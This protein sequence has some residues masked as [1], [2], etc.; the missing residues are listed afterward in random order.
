M[1]EFINTIDLLGDEV[2]ASRLI[3]KTITEFKDDI[4]TTFATYA[5]CECVNLTTV[6]LPSV[7]NIPERA[8]DNCTSLATLILPNLLS[9]GTNAFHKCTSL[10]TVNLPS[11]TSIGNSTFSEC[12]S[13]AT[14]NLPNVTNINNNGVRDCPTLVKIDLPKVTNIGDYAF[15][16]TRLKHVVLRSNT[17]CTLGGTSA[18]QTQSPQSW[19]HFYVPRALVEEYKVATNW[20]KYASY[21]YA[22]EDYTVDGTTTGELDET[23]I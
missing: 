20:T 9:T 1:N 8:F 2:V 11:V 17:L 15:Y 23:K 7:I 21:I 22:L 16:G 10:A 19:L 5:F 14:L 13:L 12:A 18:F 4:L 3:D 6:D